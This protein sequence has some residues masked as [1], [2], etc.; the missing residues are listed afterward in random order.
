MSLVRA[1]V[2]LSASLLSVSAWAQEG[3]MRPGLW[4]F[5][6]SGMPMKQ[7]IC[8]TPDMTKDVTKMGRDDKGPQTDCKS[9]TPKVSGK[10]TTFTMSCTKPNKMNSKMTLTT[11]SPD[12]FTMTQDYDMEMGG[13]H[14]KGTTTMNYKRLGDCQ[15]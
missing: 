13:Q 4:E 15:K 14:Q 8:I 11:H 3:A 10:T 1:V 12:S 5:S 2:V 7:T 9:S 6:M